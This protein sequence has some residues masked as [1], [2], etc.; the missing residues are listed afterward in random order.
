[1]LID[2]KNCLGWCHGSLETEVE[3]IWSCAF[4]LSSAVASRVEVLSYCSPQRE[5]LSRVLEGPY[6]SWRCQYWKFPQCC[7]KMVTNLDSFSLG[8]VRKERS[9]ALWSPGFMPSVVW[10][11]AAAPSPIYHTK[12]GSRSFHKHFNDVVHDKDIWL[13]FIS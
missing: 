2:Q 12:T 7:R 1:M 9:L 8:W 3:Q 4:D 10:T 11:P 13:L 5:L 6:T